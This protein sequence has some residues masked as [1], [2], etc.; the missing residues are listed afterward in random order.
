MR[1]AAMTPVAAPRPIAPAPATKRRRVIREFDLDIRLPPCDG[2]LAGRLIAPRL[3]Q[4]HPQRDYTGLPAGGSFVYER[5]RHSA[6]AAGRV[7]ALRMVGRGT[8]RFKSRL[9]QERQVLTCWSGSAAI[10]GPF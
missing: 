2:P 1:G 9:R 4:R 5:S 8:M 7:N 10:P 6:P 3:C